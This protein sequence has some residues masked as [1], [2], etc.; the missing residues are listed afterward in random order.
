MASGL[1][2]SSAREA[3]GSDAE[4][5]RAVPASNYVYDDDD[6]DED[7]DEEEGAAGQELMRLDGTLLSRAFAH[8][9][10]LT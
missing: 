5:E 1:E 3:E 7:E 6:D 2:I 8:S 10:D 9:R 4:S